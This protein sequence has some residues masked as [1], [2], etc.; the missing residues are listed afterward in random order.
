MVRATF[1]DAESW[2][3]WCGPVVSVERIPGAWESGERLD[4]DLQSLVRVR[5]AVTLEHVDEVSIR[6]SST[7]GP[8]RG[9]RTFTFEPGAIVDEK[10]FESWLP[11]ALFYPRPPIRRMSE[12]WLQDLARESERRAR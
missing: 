4:Y 2:P 8:I 9:T 3:S 12:R 11:V 6:W 10:R 5:F 7:K 1:E